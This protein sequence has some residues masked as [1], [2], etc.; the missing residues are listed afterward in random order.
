MGVSKGVKILALL[1]GVAGV[2]LLFSFF[3][4]IF[5]VGYC[6][7]FWVL[8]EAGYLSL[9]SVGFSFRGSSNSDEMTFYLSCYGY[10]GF[11]VN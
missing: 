6:K 8:G 1:L 4:F 5:L 10:E 11:H 2:E 9:R 7:A 3:F